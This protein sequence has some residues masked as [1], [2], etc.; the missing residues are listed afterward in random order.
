MEQSE[1]APGAP[2]GIKLTFCCLEA[3]HPKYGPGEASAGQ[4]GGRKE[5]ESIPESVDIFLL[6]QISYHHK[7]LETPVRNDLSETQPRTHS[8]HSF[9]LFGKHPPPRAPLTFQTS[10]RSKAVLR[11]TFQGRENQRSQKLEELFKL[12]QRPLARLSTGLLASQSA[13]VL[14]C[15]LFF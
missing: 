3:L 9:V 4:K 13:G 6:V 1:N 12:E 7:F 2:S 10:S 14:F 11:C 8:S 15:F 5:V